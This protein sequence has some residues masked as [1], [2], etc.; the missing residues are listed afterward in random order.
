[1]PITMLIPTNGY[2]KKN[3]QFIKRLPIV[4]IVIIKLYKYFAI[5]STNEGG[6]G[7]DR[8]SDELCSEDEVE[9]I[10]DKRK[11]SIISRIISNTKP[12]LTPAANPKPTQRNNIFNLSRVGNRL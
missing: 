2:F 10:D 9:C 12:T 8:L 5:I 11:L 7:D 6:E 4:K 3:S 1:M